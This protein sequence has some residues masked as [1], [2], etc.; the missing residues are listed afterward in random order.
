MAMTKA[1]RAHRHTVS[2]LSPHAFV[3]DE[4]ARFLGHARFRLQP[5]RLESGLA[6]DL[7]RLSIP[8]ATLHVV[9]AHMS[10]TL[11]QDVVA[12]VRKRQ[13][14]ARLVVLA[15]RFT[16]SSGFLLLRLGVKGLI[17]YGEAR[18]QLPQALEEVARGGFWVP[19]HLLSRF[20]DATLRGPG[21]GLRRSAVEMSPREHEVLHTV[22]ENLSNKEIATRL[23]ISERTVKFHVSNLLAKFRAPN[24]RQLMLE[25]LQIHPS[26]PELSRRTVVPLS[27]N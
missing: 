17:P 10:R 4:L 16:D 3:L 14:N 2:L 22:I 9:D 12:I 23:H 1:G 18:E 27:S 5:L 7:S 26:G 15:E 19:R 11:L 6:P 20:V 25:C 8:R 24:R 13:P 21:S